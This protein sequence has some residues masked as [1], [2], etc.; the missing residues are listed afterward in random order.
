M[1]HEWQIVSLNMY[2][3]RS[4][5]STK[6]WN[7]GG[8]EYTVSQDTSAS[9]HGHGQQQRFLNTFMKWKSTIYSPSI[10][11]IKSLDFRAINKLDTELLSSDSFNT[12]ATVF[13]TVIQWLQSKIPVGL[14]SVII[15]VSLSYRNW[16]LITDFREEYLRKYLIVL[17]KLFVLKPTHQFS[18]KYT[19]T[20][21]TLF[22]KEM[23]H[24]NFYYTFYPAKAL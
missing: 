3:S 20:C 24:Y 7:G 1:T 21:T 15:A 12:I 17:Y 10:W 8:T 4:I 19:F 22:D 5:N 23:N 16:T 18:Y 6:Y 13:I 2:L 9:Y 11:S 14:Y